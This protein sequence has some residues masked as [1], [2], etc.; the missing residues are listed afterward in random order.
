[1]STAETLNARVSPWLLSL[2]RIVAAFLF[3][4]H[5][6][7]KLLSFPAPPNNPID[8]MSL[9][10]AAGALELFGGVLLLVGL[11]SRPIAFIL[12]GMMAVAYF[13]VHAPQ[14]FWPLL[15][16]GELAALY[17]FVFLYLAFAGPGPLSLDRLFGGR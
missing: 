15:N 1:M 8:I 4:Q 14:G 6:G 11:F 3:M 5:G 2:M 10:G 17:S 13:M 7:Q 12:S 16:Q 9:M